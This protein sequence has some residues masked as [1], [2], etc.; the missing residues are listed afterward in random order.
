MYQPIEAP[1][2]PLTR[3]DAAFLSTRAEQ[4][5]SES[6]RL[7]AHAR[8]WLEMADVWDEVADTFRRRLTG[9]V[10]L[11]PP[12]APVGDPADSED[13]PPCEKATREALGQ[14]PHAGRDPY[15]PSTLPHL[16]RFDGAVQVDDASPSEPMPE[17]VR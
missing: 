16:P 4:A 15:G 3:D 7:R 8:S 17:G 12:L 1:E 13:P 11:L 5:E 14:D 2:S 9:P 10:S 6:A